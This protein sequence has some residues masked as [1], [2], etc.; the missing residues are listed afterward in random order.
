MHSHRGNFGS[1]YPQTE[2]PLGDPFS[3]YLLGTYY[4]LGT[5]LLCLDERSVGNG[6]LQHNSWK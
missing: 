1:T 6:V 3:K 2:S 5:E 4:L